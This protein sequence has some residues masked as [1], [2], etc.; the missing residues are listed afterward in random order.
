SGFPVMGLG[1][2][3]QNTG[4]GSQAVRLP[5]NYANNRMSWPTSHRANL[6]VLLK[7]IGGL[8]WAAEFC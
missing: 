5:K 8:E 7:L 1:R 2:K 4:Y 6:V 3:N